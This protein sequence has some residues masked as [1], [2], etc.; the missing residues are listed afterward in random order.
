M[1]SSFHA[2]PLERS[3]TTAPWSARAHFLLP[4]VE[5]A[6]SEARRRTR[7]QLCEWRTPEDTS[8]NA[9]LIVSEL[10]TNALRHTTSRSVGC[11]LRVSGTLLRVAVLGEGAGPRRGPAVA[12]DEDEG[13]RGL[14]LV[15][16]LSLGWG[17]R[18]TDAGRRHV[19]WADLPLQHEPA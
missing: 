19:V 5:T 1:A 6:V 4:A 18:P 17:V 2:Q 3:D 16:A 14:L 7:S 11:E 10:V 15:V 9:Q 13:G 8:D 12:T